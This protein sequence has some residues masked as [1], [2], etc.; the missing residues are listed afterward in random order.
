MTAAE[1][2]YDEIHYGGR[3]SV[4]RHR[5]TKEFSEIYGRTAF[6]KSFAKMSVDSVTVYAHT[7]L[8]ATD[9]TINPAEIASY[10]SGMQLGCLLALHSILPDVE[11]KMKKSRIVGFDIYERGYPGLSEEQVSLITLEFY[12]KLDEVVEHLDTEMQ[13]A[14]LTAAEHLYEDYPG[15][16]APTQKRQFTFGFVNSAIKMAQILKGLEEG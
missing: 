16:I 10:C 8:I 15:Y 13:E 7:T 6:A 11:D 4:L 3:G 5:W 2:I 1:R 9:D 12:E 14:I